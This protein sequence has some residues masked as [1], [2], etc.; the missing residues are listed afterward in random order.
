MRYLVVS[1]IHGSNIY[2][3]KLIDIIEIEKPDKIILL[4]DLYN[5]HSSDMIVPSV[6]N[7]YQDIIICTRGNCD[8]FYDEYISKFKFEDYIKLKIENK[9]FFFSHGH[10]YNMYNI[11]NNIDILIYGHLHTGFI[12]RINNILV[13]NTGSLSYPRNNTKNSYLLIDDKYI[14]LKDIDTNILDYIMYN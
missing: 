2:I 14:Y 11:P 13:I 1:D 8:T 6:L 12:K 9:K 7:S 10:I 4:G 5:H 3:N